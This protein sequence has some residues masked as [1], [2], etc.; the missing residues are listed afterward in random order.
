MTSFTKLRQAMNAA[1]QRSIALKWTPNNV[2]EFR[3]EAKEETEAWIVVFNILDEL[4][5]ISNKIDDFGG[6][7]IAIE[8]YAEDTLKAA[9][10]LLEFLNSGKS[11]T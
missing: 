8:S 9:Q 10:E 5:H 11:P 7:A 4:E 6:L 3:E 2:P 1:R